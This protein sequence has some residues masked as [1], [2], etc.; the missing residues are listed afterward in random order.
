MV[1][2]VSKKHAKIILLKNKLYIVD[3]NSTNGVIVNSESVEKKELKKGDIIKL[4]ES[5]IKIK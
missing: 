4:G 5:I 3:L 1:H 2:R